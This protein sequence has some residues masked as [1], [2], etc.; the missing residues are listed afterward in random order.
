[1]QQKQP[2]ICKDFIPPISSDFGV[3]FAFRDK[4]CIGFERSA[5]P[6][7]AAARGGAHAQPAGSLPLTRR[8]PG[9]S[10]AAGATP[11]PEPV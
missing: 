6:V 10:Y 5:G 2:R 11:C 1:M 8:H 9:R 3:G 4:G 7:P